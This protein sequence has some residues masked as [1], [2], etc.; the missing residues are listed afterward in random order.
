MLFS[1][2]SVR[3]WVEISKRNCYDEEDVLNKVGRQSDAL[4]SPS[5]EPFSTVS[6]EFRKLLTQEFTEPTRPGQAL[7]L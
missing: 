1:A 5:I 4:L 6:L 3:S 2:S 7:G